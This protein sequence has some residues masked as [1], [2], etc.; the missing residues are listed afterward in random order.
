MT[1][2]KVLNVFISMKSRLNVYEIFATKVRNNWRREGG[3]RR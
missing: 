3:T 2:F 1:N